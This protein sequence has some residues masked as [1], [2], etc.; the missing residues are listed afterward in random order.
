MHVYIYPYNFLPYPFPPLPRST[1]CFL[2]HV[3]AHL[4]DVSA[5]VVSSDDRARAY[6]GTSLRN[7]Y[8]AYWVPSPPGKH[9][10]QNCT[11]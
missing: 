8:L 1:T 10:F 5:C 9:S 7:G 6:F 3:H 11:I 4:C 2:K